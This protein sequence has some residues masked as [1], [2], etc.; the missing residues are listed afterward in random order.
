VYQVADVNSNE[1]G[2]N[3]RFGVRPRAVAIIGAVF[4]ARGLFCRDAEAA[5][6][7]PVRT[8]VLDQVSGDSEFSADLH[9]LAVCQQDGTLA[10]WNVAT[11]ERT[12]AG[13]NGGNLAFLPRSVE[14]LVAEGTNITVQELLTGRILRRL[15]SPTYPITSLTVSERSNVAAGTIGSGAIYNPGNRL[16][17]S[18]HTQLVFWNLADGR[19]F[20][21]SPASRY[22]W[23]S[24]F[25]GVNRSGSWAGAPLMLPISVTAGLCRAFSPDGGRFAVG[26][27]Y[28]MVDLWSPAGSNYNHYLGT[29]PGPGNYGLSS[30]GLT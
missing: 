30:S 19:I 21:Q 12:G 23:E 29:L 13:S 28:G 15:E 5:D 7:P 22:P 18:S 16:I 2:K 11:G 9:W 26:L 17:T 4:I 20:W 25:R 14:L 1:I 6:L 24:V 3:V 10:V 8:F 27:E